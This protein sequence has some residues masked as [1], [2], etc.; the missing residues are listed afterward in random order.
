MA[1]TQILQPSSKRAAD[2][3]TRDAKSYVKR[4]TKSRAAARKALVDAGIYTPNG[5]I[6]KKRK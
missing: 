6:S 5:K 2:K 3:F 4:V 1:D